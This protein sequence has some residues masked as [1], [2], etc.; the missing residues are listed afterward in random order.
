MGHEAI[1]AYKP[2]KCVVRGLVAS[3][4]I[5]PFAGYSVP[6][7]RA[8]DGHRYTERIGTPNTIIGVRGRVIKSVSVV[9]SSTLVLSPYRSI[10]AL[11]PIRSTWEGSTT[12]LGAVVGCCVAKTVGGTVGG[13]VGVSELQATRR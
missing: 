2:Q 5:R 12:A 7:A 10:H 9:G 1:Y 11:S 4:I 13:D 3:R 8:S 6:L